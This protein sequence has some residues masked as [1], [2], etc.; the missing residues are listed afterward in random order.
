MN[1]EVKKTQQFRSIQHNLDLNNQY[2]IPQ[3][4]E[5][6]HSNMPEFFEGIM[7]WTASYLITLIFTALPKGLLRENTW[8]LINQW[9]LPVLFQY[10]C[11]QML[12][13]YFITYIK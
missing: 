9:K 2:H 13:L 11:Y 5:N 8:K 1:L 4:K 10:H 7:H 6:W 12:L 3:G